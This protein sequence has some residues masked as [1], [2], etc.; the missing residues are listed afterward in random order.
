MT[1]LKP[2]QWSK[3]LPLAEFWYNTSYHASLKSSPFQVLYGYSPPISTFPQTPSSG[4]LEVDRF[5]KD[6]TEAFQ[7]IK[8]NLRMAQQR[9]KFYADRHRTD[10]SF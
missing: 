9:M 3:W 7:L 8:E 4:V 2:S 1:S 5:L 10:R 6:R